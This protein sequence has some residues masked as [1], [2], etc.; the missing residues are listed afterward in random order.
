MIIARMDLFSFE[1]VF[2][3][4]ELD[5]LTVCGMCVNCSTLR[6]DRCLFVVNNNG[7]ECMAI[8]GNSARFDSSVQAEFYRLFRFPFC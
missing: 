6:F 1:G 8:V 5:C 7:R 2:S 3:G 4:N